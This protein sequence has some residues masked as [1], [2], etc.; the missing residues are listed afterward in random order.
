MHGDDLFR[1]LA[2]EC[3]DPQL[4]KDAVQETFMRLHQHTPT[5]DGAIRMWLFRTGMNVVRDERRK[6]ANRRRL[7]A[8]HPDRVPIPSTDP[9]PERRAELEDDVARLR[10]AL[11]S[12]REKERTALL[13][14]ESGFSHREIAE[15]L[16]T[17]TGTV[18]TLIAR[19]LRKLA[20]AMEH[21]DGIP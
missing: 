13:M 2:R 11:A 6:T 19:S 21:P 9:D 10:K 8:S 4:A 7:L 12:L 18:G 15:E 17:T 5:N 16:D 1:H 20:A 14:R 3:G